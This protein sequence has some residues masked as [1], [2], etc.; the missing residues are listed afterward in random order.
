MKQVVDDL[1]YYPT[2]WRDTE[3]KINYRRFF[4]SNSLICLNIQHEKVFATCHAMI[5]RWLDRKMI[6]GIRVDHIDGLY[7]PSEYLDRLRKLAGN[8]MVIYIEKILERDEYLPDNWP[9][10]GSTGYDFL[11]M[12]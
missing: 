12:V 4:T 9:I 5:G 10:E 7:N 2:F 1:Y 8:D 3:K 6:D 11:G